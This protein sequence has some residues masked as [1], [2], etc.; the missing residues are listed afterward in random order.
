MA[1]EEER[2]QAEKRTEDRAWSISWVLLG[3]KERERD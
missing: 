2:L 1:L 3:E